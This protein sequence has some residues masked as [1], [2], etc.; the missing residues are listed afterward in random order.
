VQIERHGNIKIML[1]TWKLAAEEMEDDKGPV[2]ILLCVMEVPCS[3]PEPKTGY[4]H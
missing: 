3:N 1:T 4:H 2:H